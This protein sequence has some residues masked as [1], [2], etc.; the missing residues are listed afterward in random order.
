MR[1]QREAA[2]ELQRFLGR[3]AL[4]RC[5]LDLAR[6]RG[7]LLGEVGGVHKTSAPPSCVPDS[8]IRSDAR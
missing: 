8:G 6:G 4:A 7:V 3:V 2:L 5:G 1:P